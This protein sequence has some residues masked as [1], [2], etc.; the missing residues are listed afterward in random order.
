MWKQ[1][2][3]YAEGWVICAGLL[4]TGFGLQLITGPVQAG[5]FQYPVNVA[6]GLIFLLVLCIGF[7]VGRKI[8]VVQWFSGLTASITSLSALLS[9]V[10][11]MGF[12]GPGIE[13]ITM[14]WPFILLFLYFLFVLGF[15]TLKRIVSFRWRDVPFMLN[16]VGLFITLL[17]AILGNGDLRRLRMTVPLENPEWRASDEKNEMI[18]LPL[19]IELRSFTIDEY[20]PK[21]MLIDNTTGKALPEK[22]P[23][24]ILV[25]E[26]PLAGNL[27]GWKVE[28]TR[29]LPMAACVMGQDTI[30][31][32]EFHSEGATTAL[33]VKARNELTGRQK[34]GWVSCGSYI[35]PY[36]SLQLDD[37]VSMVMPEREPRRFASDVMVY[38][39]D[40]QTKEARIEVNKPLSIAGWKIYQLSYDETKGKW[41][42]MSVFEL[43]R[44]PWLP[45]VYTGIL[46]MIAGA[47]G[48]FLSAPVK[49][50]SMD[51]SYFIY[52]AA[53][54]LFCWIGGAWLAY[55]PSFSKGAVAWTVFGLAIFSA[56]IIGMWISLERPPLRTVGETRLWYSFFL[57]VAGVITYVRWR[58]KWILSFSTLLAFVFIC[59]NLF[60]PEI[61]NKTLMPALQ[62]PWFAPHVIVYM[63]SYAMLGAAALIAIYLLI[64]ARKKGID[65][66][67]M[68][69]CDNLVYVGMA[70]LTIGMLFG[71]L[72]AKE[73][74][75]HYWNWDPKETWA[76]ATWLGY[77]I[78]IHY[79]LHHR[80][81]YSAALGLL[82]FSFL[83]LQVCW[84]GVN[85]LPSAQ[86]YSVHTY[87][88]E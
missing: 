21:L 39:K 59:V 50:N 79:R 7:V 62:S 71:A 65:E 66:G 3:G 23:E 82:V 24:N 10:L 76:A 55:R 32:V 40:K 38:T 81:R 72:W 45:I 52:F 12:V 6:G 60:K 41:S 74:W 57:P 20:P 80:L 44:D 87:N 16:H 30:N 15:V 19:A 11:V 61:H 86:G 27:Q 47:I 85:Y 42:R 1:P 25:E 51:W 17:A 14:S 26:I 53:P 77:L 84:V 70:F 2:W 43:V 49:K 58:Y 31:F 18:E 69:L 46:M 8:T 68:S 35:F 29:S 78:Y 37:A 64:R 36:I 56:F 75:G 4:I 33:Y 34:E 48:L 88:M 73:A 9:V 83:L 54:A 28:V 22:Q 63:F 5:L 13:R 67:M